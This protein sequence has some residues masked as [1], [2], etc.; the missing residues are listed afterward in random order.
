MFCSGSDVRGAF[1]GFLGGVLMLRVPCWGFF[2]GVKMFGVPCRSSLLGVGARCIM[3]E[4]FGWVRWISVAFAMW[5][6]ED[7]GER[8][9]C[10]AWRLLLCVVAA[11]PCGWVCV[12]V[13]VGG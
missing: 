3:L 11:V 5:R 13:E 1:W 7:V 9:V 8:G 10:V 4:C 6:S 12:S 2:G